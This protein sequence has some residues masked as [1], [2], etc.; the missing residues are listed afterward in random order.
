MDLKRKETIFTTIGQLQR[1][2]TQ[3]VV[4][5]SLEPHSQAV[6]DSLGR[7]SLKGDTRK[8]WMGRKSQKHRISPSGRRRITTIVLEGQAIRMNK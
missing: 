8:S 5:G 2:R 4:G 1:D 6:S 3:R 7:I